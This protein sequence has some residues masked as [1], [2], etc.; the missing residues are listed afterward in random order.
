MKR[1]FKSINVRELLR[2]LGQLIGFSLGSAVVLS[3]IALILALIL[4]QTSVGVAVMDRFKASLFF[5]T[6]TNLPQVLIDGLTIGF[7]Y[8]AVA[9]G[10]TMVYGVLEFINFSHSEIFATGA[11]VGVEILIALDKLGILASASLGIAYVFLVFAILTGM[12]AAGA[13]VYSRPRSTFGFLVLVISFF[14]LYYLKADNRFKLM[15]GIILADKG[16]SLVW[17]RV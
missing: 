15:T 11:S 14:S 6:L 10:Y 7:I 2:P 12:I 16:V 5:Y 8:A 13:L 17:S 1:F 3:A 9:L 4:D